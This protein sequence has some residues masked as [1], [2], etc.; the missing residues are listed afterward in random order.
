MAN[1]GPV[2]SGQ[3]A[4][5]L[6]YNNLRADV[7]DPTTG[8]RHDGLGAVAA[9]LSLLGD[10]ADGDVTISGNTTL[11][12]D[13][14]YNSLT[15]NAGVVLTTDGYRIFVKGTCNVLGTVRN[16]GN[17]GSPGAAGFDAYAGSGVVGRQFLRLPRRRGRHGWDRAIRSSRRSRSAPAR[18]GARLPTTAART[19]PAATRPGRA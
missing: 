12:R 13:M 19:R 8:H 3:Q 1:S 4:T 6:Q 9:L 16:N 5:A 10:G 14:F 17:P 15:V 7:V 11:T 18:P 2:S